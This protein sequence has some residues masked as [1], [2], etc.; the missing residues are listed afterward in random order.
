MSGA[1]ELLCCSCLPSHPHVFAFIGVNKFLEFLQPPS[2]EAQSPLISQNNQR[3]KMSQELIPRIQ[4]KVLCSLLG[5]CH[6]DT[7]VA[8]TLC[9]M[10]ARCVACNAQSISFS[11]SVPTLFFP[12]RKSVYPGLQNYAILSLCGLCLSYTFM[13]SSSMGTEVYPFLSIPDTQHSP[14]HISTL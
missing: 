8:T 11:F 1:V 14:Q 5:R 4:Y 7:E 13:T 6:Q 2:L 10:Q 3:V 9:V 12:A